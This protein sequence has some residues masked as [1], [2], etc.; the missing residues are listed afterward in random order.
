MAAPS[1]AGTISYEVNGE[2]YIATTN[3]AGSQP[4]SQGNNG[5]SVFAFKVGGTAKYY[6]GPRSSPVYV[7]GGSEA[8]N[9]TPIPGWRR[10][11]DNTAAGIVPANEVWMARSNNTA[12]STGDSVNTNSMI[13]SVRTVSVGTTVTF[14]N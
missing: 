4:Y 9:G 3:V 2:Q 1:Q 6:T 5:Q 14:R 8:P 7:T 11:T 12:T 10:P 13:P